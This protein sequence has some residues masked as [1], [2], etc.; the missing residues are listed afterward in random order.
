MVANKNQKSALAIYIAIPTNG[1]NVW[2]EECKKLE[3]YQRMKDEPEMWK[4]KLIPVII[5]PLETI[6]AKLEKFF[7]FQEQ[8]HELCSEQRTTRNN[9]IMQTSGRGLKVE[10]SSCLK[11]MRK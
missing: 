1:K 9:K 5:A 3:K 2:K 11:R 6:S 8:H 10:D 7:R 4:I